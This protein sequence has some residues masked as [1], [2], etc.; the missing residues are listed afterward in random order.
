MS[1]F[2]LAGLMVLTL[3]TS[4]LAEV[5]VNINDHNYEV[6]VGN[7]V[8]KYMN[9]SGIGGL[10]ATI[11]RF[12]MT[13][14]P[15]LALNSVYSS[16]GVTIN[17]FQHPNE[18]NAY[19]FTGWAENG[20]LPNEF[21]LTMNFQGLVE[22]MNYICI[23]DIYFSDGGY[24]SY[25]YTGPAVYGIEGTLRVVPTIKLSAK[26]TGNMNEYSILSFYGLNGINGFC[27]VIRY[28]P[29]AINIVSINCKVEDVYLWTLPAG[30]GFLLCMGWTY[31]RSLPTSTFFAVGYQGLKPGTTGLVIDPLWFNNGRIWRQYVPQN[32]ELETEFIIN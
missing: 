32:N 16:E 11:F 10:K 26:W 20:N 3:A 8:D 2:A 21:R 25:L 6:A 28:D 24:K 30:P 23:R 22:G 27:F 29:E 5:Y 15:N 4:S 19:F 18:D 12:Y 9:F 1:L 14:P 31:G 17:Y 7:N 13:F